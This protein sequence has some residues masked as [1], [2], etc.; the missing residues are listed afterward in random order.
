LNDFES[1]QKGFTK[2]I[3]AYGCLGIMRVN[4]GQSVTSTL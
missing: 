1:M 3:D 2:T 4:A